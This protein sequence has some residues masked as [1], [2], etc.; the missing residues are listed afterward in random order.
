MDDR[1]RPGLAPSADYH[2]PVLLEEVLGFLLPSPGPVLDGTV[3]G[4]G[5]SRALLERDP[6]LELIAVDR[7][8]EALGAAA[9][10]ME[11][12]ADRVR[13]VQ[14]EF[15]DAVTAAGLPGEVLGGVLLD[16]GVSS[17]HLDSDARGFAF[18]T[19]VP[20]D[21]RM[22]GASSAESSAADLLATL[23]Q[24]ELARIF[25]EFGEE[26]R[27]RALAREIVR[28]REAGDVLTT[29]DDLVAALTRALG[30]PAR[31]GEKARVF[32]ALRIAVNRELD[33]LSEALPRLRDALRPTGVMAIIAYHSLEDRIVKRAF[34][35]WSDACI[36]PPDL[37]VCACGR[38][39]LG[40][41]L[42]RK[43][44]RPSEEEVERNPRARSALLRA[45]RKAA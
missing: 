10:A 22:A 6:S 25:F 18:R 19:G 15:S 41:T 28:R 21:M 16:L 8:P 13:F 9:R 40:E 2:Q 12:V 7:D 27:A 20:L 35:E 42:T 4:G 30:R 26:P 14:A 17:R 1:L 29:S 23:P 24:A 38:E 37:P 3:G 33:G 5:H 36:C 31:S 44:V 32:Q 43:P 39:A 34:R 45:W 11:G